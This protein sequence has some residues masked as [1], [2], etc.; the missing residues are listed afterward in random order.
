MLWIDKRTWGIEASPALTVPAW[1]LMNFRWPKQDAP[2]S[3]GQDLCS[4][5]G[6]WLMSAVCEGVCANAEEEI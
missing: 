5:K 6:D 3:K 1:H 2:G 4:R